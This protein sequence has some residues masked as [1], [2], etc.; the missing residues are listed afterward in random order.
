MSPF[1]A[2]VDYFRIA[3][4]PYTIGM[5]GQKYGRWSGDLRKNSSSCPQAQTRSPRFCFIVF[6]EGF[7]VTAEELQTDPTS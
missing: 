4:H 7:A 5:S 6:R 2:Q 3:G 1:P